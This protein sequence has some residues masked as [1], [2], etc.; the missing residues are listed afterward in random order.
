MPF[1][2]GLLDAMDLPLPALHPALDGLRVAHIS[3]LHINRDRRRWRDLAAQLS[4]HR[5]DLVLMTGDYMSWPGDEKPAAEVL[6]RL[7][8][9][10]KPRYGTYAIFGNHDTVDLRDR[11]AHLP[12]TW[13]RNQIQRLETPAI[14]LLGLGSLASEPG[15]ATALAL[16]AMG[17]ASDEPAEPGETSPSG[18]G[19]AR[20]ESRRARESE[21]SEGSER[22]APVGAVP[23]GGERQDR[24]LRLMLAHR[25]EAIPTASDLGMDLVLLG[26]THGGQCRLPGKRA[27]ITSSSFPGS[28]AAG[29]FRHR[30]TLA[31]LTRGAGEI[32]LPFRTFCRAHVPL[33][34]LR[35]RPLPGQG[36]PAIQLLQRW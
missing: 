34:T 23:A 15:D 22:V 21:G 25:P 13:L 32:V 5:V 17:H 36:G 24:P 19:T 18:A 26:H 9:S 1:S 12:I 2:Y 30:Q 27:L 10:L 20:E 33:Y 8:E 7:S 29:L 35:Q 31:A 11:L 3:D 4:R 14:D 16:A 28:M 6:E